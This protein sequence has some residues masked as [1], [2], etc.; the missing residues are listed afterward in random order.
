VTRHESEALASM[1]HEC[2]VLDRS[3]LGGGPEPW[4]ADAAAVKKLETLGDFDLAHFY[5]GTF[6]DTAHRLKSRGCRISWTIAAHSVAVSK[7]EHEKLGIGFPYEHL[8]SPELWRRYIEGY[9]LADVIVCPGSVPAQTVRE[10]GGEFAIKRIEIIPH[11]CDLPTEKCQVCDGLGDTT[12]P[13]EDGGSPLLICDKC[14]G[15]GSIT[16]PPTSLP[17]RF[18]VGY[19]GS[20]GAPDKG[21]RYL[22]EAW[23]R[24]NYADALLILAGRDSTSPWVRQMWQQFGGGNVH[25]AGWQED[26]SSFYDSISLYIQPSASEGFGIEVVES[27]AAGRPVLCS[28]GAGACDVVAPTMTF[29]ACDADALADAIHNARAGW[30]PDQEQCL[31]AAAKYTWGK[32]RQQYV[33]LWQ[34]LLNQEKNQ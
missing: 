21:V 19:L 13:S 22:M 29:P 2:V 14:S 12:W 4:G 25:F 18:V 26:V 7:R 32:V 10:Y 30:H 15:R 6:G 16:T 5:A 20:C 1:G 23:K 9:R 8:T 28:R 3:V 31:R 34:S 33:D 27:L 24:L 17:D 11:G